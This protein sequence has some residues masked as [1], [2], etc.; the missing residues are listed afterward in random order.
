MHGFFRFTGTC[1]PFTG[2]RKTL[3]GTGK[4]ST[5]AGKALIGTGKPSTGTGKALIGTGKPFTGTG[6]A[7]TD[8]AEKPPPALRS[9]AVVQCRRSK[10]RRPHTKS[11][12]PYNQLA[13]F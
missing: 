13:G 9:G 7:L 11:A 1:Q 12:I 10:C 4:P 3:I 8:T 2:A 6:K 5:G